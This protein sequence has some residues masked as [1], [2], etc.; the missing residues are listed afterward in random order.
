MKPAKQF[1][2]VVERQDPAIHEVAQLFVVGRVAGT[3]DECWTQAKEL[4]RY[5]VLR[6]K[7][8]QNVSAAVSV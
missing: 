2:A 5:P 8:L 3:H 6:L 4:T 7:E 1:S